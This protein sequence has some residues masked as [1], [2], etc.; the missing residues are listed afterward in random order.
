MKRTQLQTDWAKEIAR[1]KRF[2]KR[3]EKRGFS[4]ADYKIP[5]KPKRITKQRLEE[6]RAETTPV[7]MYKQS[8][9]TT[10]E[11]EIISGYQG[12]LYSRNKA[13]L[14]TEADIVIDNLRNVLSSWKVQAPS[15]RRINRE[16]CDDIIQYLDNAIATIGKVN[17]AR[18]IQENAEYL[19]K[20]IEISVT[21]SRPEEIGMS[22]SIVASI[23]SGRALTME[24]SDALDGERGWGSLI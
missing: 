1:I 11:G 13:K 2:I 15:Q 6:L 18:N 3:A 5:E 8:E 10:P 22:L 12:M 17:V 9:Y 20:Q 23:L 21:A 19:Y 14:G 7:K 24:E 4:F 16:A